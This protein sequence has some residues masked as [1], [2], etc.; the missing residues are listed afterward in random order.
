[1]TSELT[2]LAMRINAEHAA[3]EQAAETA[4]ERARRA[5]ELLIEAKEKVPHGQW[6]PWLAENITMPK[7]T[8]QAYMALAHGLPQL[9]PEDAQRVAHLPLRKALQTVGRNAGVLGKLEPDE[10]REVIDALAGGQQV[11]QVRA[12]ISRRKAFHAP[13]TTSGLTF[14]LR[15]DQKATI[16]LESGGSCSVKVW[17]NA[18]GEKFT[19]TEWTSMLEERMESAEELIPIRDYRDTAQRLAKKLREQLRI[20][21][22]AANEARVML[23]RGADL[24]LEIE[25]GKPSWGAYIFR[26]FSPEVFQALAALPPEKLSALASDI[27]TCTGEELRV[28]LIAQGVLSDDSPPIDDIH[29]MLICSSGVQQ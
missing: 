27:L 13:P 10:R 12:E 16:K 7:R 15:T 20:A 11:S 5:G 19:P 22:S 24:L 2:A 25:H 14:Q 18:V 28:R 17:P 8:A 4:V 23:R 9:A 3:A 1:M 21:E 6:L 26:D 29:G